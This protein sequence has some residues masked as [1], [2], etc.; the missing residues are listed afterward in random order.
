MRIV[1]LTDLHVGLED[2]DTYG[3]NVRQNFLRILDKAKAQ[4]PDLLVVSG[5]LCYRDGDARI[6][7]WIKSHLDQSGLPYEVMSGNHDDPALL[8]QTFGREDL[9]KGRELYFSR[10][11]AG[12]TIL[13]LDTTTYEISATQL[14]WLE[15]SLKAIDGPAL[16]FMHHPPLPS[17]VPFMDTKHSL[18]NMSAVQKVF[19]QHPHPVQVFTG[20]YH[21][22]KV[23]TKHNLTVYITP[24][25]FFQIGQRSE[26]FEVDHYRIALRTIDWSNG[27]MMNAVHYL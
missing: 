26:A 27:L 17:G 5:D 24:S 7:Q 15:A 21:V 13:F 6:Y 3:V 23:V 14:Q 12:R 9:L 2:E 8:A 16:V 22:E 4:D 25:C 1:Q 19:F 20:H 10:S 18:R 11:Y